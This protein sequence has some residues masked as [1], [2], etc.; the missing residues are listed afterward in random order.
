MNVAEAMPTQSQQAKPKL[1][2]AL[3][4]ARRH[5]LRPVFDAL[6]ALALFA[7]ASMTLVSAPT[8]AS[9]T[10]F[11]RN[12]IAPSIVVAANVT[13]TGSMLM[14]TH[15]VPAPMAGAGPSMT[16]KHTAWGLLA[17]AF[18]LLAA[19]NLAFFRHLRQAYISPRKRR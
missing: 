8:S 14:Q 4:G 13:P 18:S 3:I 6:V 10:S 19:M 17:M 15:T 9:P 5:L 7:T 2:G 11:G 12:A 1:Q 16:G